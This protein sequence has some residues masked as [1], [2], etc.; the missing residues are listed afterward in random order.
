MK[1]HID[2]FRDSTWSSVE[3]GD[4]SL[5]SVPSAQK[6]IEKRDNNKEMLEIPFA[7]SYSMFDNVKN[8]SDVG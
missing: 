2:G 7:L 8:C 4:T 5:T 3:N 1:L 6:L